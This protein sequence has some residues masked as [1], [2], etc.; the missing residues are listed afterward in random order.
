MELP[1]EQGKHW[2]IRDKTDFMYVLYKQNVMKQ[3]Y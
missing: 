3:K 1:P 2:T